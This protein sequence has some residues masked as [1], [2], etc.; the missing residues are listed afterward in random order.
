MSS[1]T[2][3]QKY[4]QERLAQFA[5][6]HA[7]SLQQPSSH[8]T[9]TIGKITFVRIPKGSFLMGDSAADRPRQN[10]LSHPVTLTR[11]FWISETPITQAQFID[12][13]GR[14]PSQ[15]KWNDDRPVDSVS[16][17]DA[18]AFC[19]AL[20]Q[21]A[22]LPEVYE[23]LPMQRNNVG[24]QIKAEFQ[25]RDFYRALGFRLPTEAEWEYVAQGPK[26]D[27]VTTYYKL[28]D[29]AWYDVN[30]EGSTQPVKTKQPNAFGV[31]DI[32]GNVKEWVQDTYAVYP[33]SQEEVID[34]LHDQGASRVTRGGSW[35]TKHVFELAP[36]YRDI[37]VMGVPYNDVGFRIVLT[38]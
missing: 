11:D 34:P 10:A 27:A 8:K 4:V 12:V 13:M 35:R 32:Q 5:N 14:N 20:S 17:D 23:L 21:R 15:F 6:T 26:T 37:V 16:W 29:A 2:E 28:Q 7:P 24:Y 31:Y 30:S 36:H 25:G 9:M 38:A 19:N 22:F 33:S 18:V 1:M 3:F